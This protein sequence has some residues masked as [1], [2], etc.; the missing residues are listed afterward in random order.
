MKKYKI[1]EYYIGIFVLSLGLYILPTTGLM[2]YSIIQVGTL[3]TWMGLLIC[4]LGLISLLYKIFFDF[5][6]G[7]FMVDESKIIMKVGFRE[8][9]HRWSDFIDY[10]FVQSSIMD[11]DL[12]WVYLSTYELSYDPR[13]LFVKKTRRDLRNIA[14]FHYNDSSFDEILS[15]MPKE[16]AAKLKEEETEVREQMSWLEEFHH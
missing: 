4:I 6:T 2:I 16:M 8:Y 7:S 12:Q 1:S 14:Y 11:G 10:G 9:E 15:F 13:R 5:G 3:L